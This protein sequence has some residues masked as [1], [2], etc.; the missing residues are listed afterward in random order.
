MAINT[1]F[2][3]AYGR[4]V[5]VSPA[6][7]TA[8]SEIGVGSKSIVLTNLGDNVCYVR[9]G[10]S[11]VTATTADY[12]VLSGQQVSLGKFQD[13]THVAYISADGTSLHIIAGEGM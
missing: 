2:N 11:T 6:A 4:G 12:P 3:P 7:T 13:Y 9:V 8:S 10:G 5:V 1:S